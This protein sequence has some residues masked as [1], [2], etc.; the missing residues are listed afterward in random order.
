MTT[1]TTISRAN[2]PL[3]TKQEFVT[4]LGYTEQGGKWVKTDDFG[5]VL[6]GTDLLVGFCPGGNLPTQWGHETMAPANEL[7]GCNNVFQ[8]KA[9]LRD[10]HPDAPNLSHASFAT[11]Y[12]A[13][14]NNTAPVFMTVADLD[15]MGDDAQ[16]LTPAARNAGIT[17]A[18]IREGLLHP[19]SNGG[20]MVWAIGDN[21]E[22]CGQKS[23]DSRFH[24]DLNVN[25]WDFA[26]P[27]GYKFPW[28][29]EYGGF[30]AVMG[31]TLSNNG[32][33]EA[34]QNWGQ[35]R[36]KVKKVTRLV[37]IGL[38]TEY[39]VWTTS[40]QAQ[41]LNYDVVNA[42]DAIRPFDTVAEETTLANMVAA[43]QRFVSNAVV[44][45]VNNMLAA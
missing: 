16:A 1:N 37:N 44:C 43:G 30:F 17:V 26:H 23:V 14:T 41:S 18:K 29:E 4:W 45:E 21:R 38:V 24:P 10:Y 40:R 8:V 7:A 20:L 35:R 22:H 31:Y 28:W 42:I 5:T 6:C 9:L 25:Q 11:C 32:F 12:N 39:C 13:Y 19:D 3:M 27:K 33:H 36:R 2:L 34:I 15:A